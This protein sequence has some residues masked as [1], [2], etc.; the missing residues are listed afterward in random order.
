VALA[1]FALVAAVDALRIHERLPTSLFGDEWRYLYYAKNLLHGLYSPRE[2]V[3]LWNGPGYPLLLVPFVKADWI[4]GARYAN[5]LWHAAA[6]AYAWLILESR[7]RASWALAA[8]AALALYIP[9]DEHLPM[10]YT[11]TVCFFLVCAWTYHSLQAEK[12]RLHVALAGCFLAALCLTKVIF[13]YPLVAFL[14]IALIGFWRTREA[15]WKVHLQQAVL[16]LALCL[17]YL[18]YTY[19]LTG[20][21]FYWSSAGGNTFYWLSSPYEGEW[22]DWYHQGWVQQNPLLRAHHKEI[23]DRTSGL[24][25]NPD[26]SP[27]E[28]VFNL[29]S[30]EAAEV[31]AKQAAQ[32]VREHP[33]KFARNWVANVARMFLDVPVSVRGTPFWNQYSVSHLILLAWTVFVAR[34]AHRAKVVLDRSWLPIALFAA[35]GFAAYSFSS[36][37]ARFLIPFVPIW[38]IG[39]CCW[40]ALASSSR[41]RHEST[42]ASS[43]PSASTS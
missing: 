30:P 12:S 37:M 29:S 19:Q 28:Q 33:L 23:F 4:D 24:G 15:L 8:T 7:M 38:W 42:E 41:S 13:G 5:A 36:G 1:V 14:V 17:P 43:E 22:G 20:K 21:A 27:E 10:L 2:R 3:F 31:F 32:N 25:N 26:L 40:L 11:E 39:S 35:L 34:R 18:I 9:L 16:A 6:M